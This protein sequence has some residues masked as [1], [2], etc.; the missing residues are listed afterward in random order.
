MQ[1]VAINSAISGHQWHSPLE[2]V[3]RE[4]VLDARGGGA[5]AA[6]EPR[7]Q[8]LQPRGAVGQRDH[9][10]LLQTAAR[11]VVELLR[12]EMMGDGGDGGRLWEMAGDGGDGWRSGDGGD[13]GRWWEMMWE[14]G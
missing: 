1:S 5:L 12:R 4:R 10:P 3:C 9:Q 8:H 14:I 13:G 6:L 2:V 7:S 11:G